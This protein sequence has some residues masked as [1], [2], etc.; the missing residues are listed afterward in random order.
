MG[1]KK[2]FIK[3]DAALY[4]S[5]AL[6]VGAFFLLMLV[7]FWPSY[8]SR[9]F[10]QP[11]IRFHLHGIA[12]TL[13]FML[14]LAQAYLIRAKRHRLHRKLGKLSYLLVPFVVIATVELVHFRLKPA[15]FLGGVEL[16]FLSLVLVALVVFLA[17]YGLAMVYRRDPA[18]HA[19]FMV[20]TVF[21]FVTPVTDRI[22]GRHFPSL[23]PL[24]PVI[25]GSPILPVIGFLLADV[26]LIA[27]AL[28][29]W[30]SSRRKDVF[31]IALALL[32]GYHV[33]VLSFY[34][35]PLWKSFGEWFVRLPLS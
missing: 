13:W 35:L 4:R 30:R 8:F 3:P 10:T 24:V 16:Y 1:K 27:L 32:V 2:T 23:V 17:L 5:S 28:W 20:C 29:D 7:A 14:L 12:L 31:P 9:P 6:Y 18:T 22:I 25:G 26:I 33:A 19:R 34:K 11:D 15:P 21:P